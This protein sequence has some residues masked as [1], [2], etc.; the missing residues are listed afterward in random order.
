MSQSEPRPG[1]VVPWLV[2]AGLVVAVASGVV[3]GF[4]APGLLLAVLLSACAV[5]RLVLP[6]RMVGLLAVRSRIVDVVT[7]SALAVGVALLALTAPGA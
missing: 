1:S 7:L 6:L 3:L 5:A 4:R 2:G